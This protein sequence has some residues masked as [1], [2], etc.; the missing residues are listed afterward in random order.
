V[1]RTKRKKQA[2]PPRTVSLLRSPSVDGVGAFR[3]TDGKESAIYAFGE[4]R[5]D[6]GGRGFAIHRLGLGNLYHLRVGMPDEC[7]C[8]CL[9][10]YRH[11]RCRHIL[12]MAALIHKRLI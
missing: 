4:I 3:I 10:F 9:G 8:E 1:A 7:S 11:G 6:V 2:R 12:G 5:C